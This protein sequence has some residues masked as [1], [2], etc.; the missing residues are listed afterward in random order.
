MKTLKIKLF[1]FVPMLLGALLLSSVPA[2]AGPVW[3]GA[4]CAFVPDDISITSYDLTDCSFK[5]EGATLSPVIARCNVTNPLDS[6]ANPGW[7]T[8]EISFVD[9]S[10]A[11]GNFVNVQLWKKSC[12]TGLASVVA[13]CSSDAFPPAAVAQCK[14]CLFAHVFDF[15]ENA[16][17]I[18]AIVD[19]SITKNTE[20]FYSVRLQ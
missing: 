7:T 19:R 15:F 1:L 18:R 8:M 16:Y 11:A 10:A 12:T 4:A 9:T 20:I 14:T 5:Q 17:Y 13:T 2:G 3:T 6:G